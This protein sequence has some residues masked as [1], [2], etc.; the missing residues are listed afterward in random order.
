[1]SLDSGESS[2][3]SIAYWVLLGISASFVMVGFAAL[4]YEKGGPKCGLKP[5]VD[6][7]RWIALITLGLQFWDFTSDISLLFELW[8][9]DDLWNERLLFVAAIGSTAF[10][11]IPFAFNLYRASTVKQ[12]VGSNEAARTWFEN[13]LP[14]FVGTVVITGGC[15]PA[16]GFVSSGIFGIDLLTSGLTK[17]EIRDLISIKIYGSV[18]LEN[19]PQLVCQMIYAVIGGLG[20]TVLFAFAAS[21]LSLISAVLTYC[22][23]RN[24]NGDDMESVHYHISIEKYKRT[25]QV[26]DL[27]LLAV[28]G[29][30]QQDRS[31]EPSVDEGDITLKD[32]EK[33]EQY[34]GWQKALSR[35]LTRFWN[36][37][38]N[39]IEVGATVITKTG[40]DTHIVHDMLRDDLQIFASELFPDENPKEVTAIAV[41]REVYDQNN[42]ALTKIF[43]DHYRFTT[44]DFKV[45]FKD[46]YLR[47]RALTQS[48]RS[49]P[50]GLKQRQMTLKNMLVRPS[51]TQIQVQLLDA[52]GD[53]KPQKSNTV[54]SSLGTDV[55]NLIHEVVMEEGS[56]MGDG[57][58][59]TAL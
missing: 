2:N 59:E 49:M 40:A 14:I 35:K 32:V 38:D 37:P 58:G 16:L 13:H 56:E 15:Y 17:H 21:L 25:D 11:I 51:V 43:R 33:V 3:Q 28:P 48:P 46:Q 26:L 6:N 34:K 29:T 22:I 41:I 47:K 23:D 4:F 19:A 54:E 42:E 31:F 45:D 20:E 57:D 27:G 10:L 18:L 9:H 24:G 12:L 53:N 8:G 55:L 1:M 52:I 39:T 30:P 50:V 36:I 7:S 5:K 44:D